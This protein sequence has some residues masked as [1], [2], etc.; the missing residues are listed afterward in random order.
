MYITNDSMETAYAGFMINN[1]INT[2][3]CVLTVFLIMKFY[4]IGIIVYTLTEYVVNVLSLM[5]PVATWLQLY[6][7]HVFLF[8][9]CYC[10]RFIHLHRKGIDVL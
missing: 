1:G 4:H 5:Y 9:C 6:I 8:G 10:Y 3:M 2:Y 7:I